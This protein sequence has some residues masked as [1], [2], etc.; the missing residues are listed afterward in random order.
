MSVKWE[1]RVERWSLGNYP[2]CWNM[3]QLLQYHDKDYA[4]EQWMIEWSVLLILL[5][6]VIQQFQTSTLGILLQ[7]RSQNN[8]SSVSLLSRHT[9][10][11]W[12]SNL[13]LLFWRQVPAVPSEP[14]SPSVVSSLL[15]HTTTATASLCTTLPFDS[16]PGPTLSW[17]LLSIPAVIASNRYLG[18]AWKWMWSMCICMEQRLWLIC[19]NTADTATHCYSLKRLEK[20]FMWS[21][22]YKEHIDIYQNQKSQC[23]K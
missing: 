3:L 2:G 10:T 6:M 21:S 9:L 12:Q 11:V 22:S 14:L 15:H 7:Q 23:N 20:T 8:K 17:S 16:R 18:S 5:D 4:V 1:H 19:I 13:L